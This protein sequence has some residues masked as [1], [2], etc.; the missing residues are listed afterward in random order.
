MSKTAA[1][2]AAVFDVKAAAVFDMMAG[3]SGGV[4]AAPVPAHRSN[5]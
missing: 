2:I 3:L 4:P 1:T 5:A